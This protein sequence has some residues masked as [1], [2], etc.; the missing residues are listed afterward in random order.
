MAA[1]GRV[2]AMQALRPA[3]APC[4]GG[5]NVHD[6]RGYPADNEASVLEVGEPTGC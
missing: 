6:V 3:G 4:I 5:G 2:A 1:T